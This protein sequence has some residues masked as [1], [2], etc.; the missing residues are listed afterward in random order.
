MKTLLSVALQEL[1]PSVPVDTLFRYVFVGVQHVEVPNIL[2]FLFGVLN[3]CLS[4][5]YY[6]FFNANR[7]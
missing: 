6:P 3:L 2:I 1:A 7:Y 4:S 5:Y